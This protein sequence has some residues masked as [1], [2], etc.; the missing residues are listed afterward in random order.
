MIIKQQCISC[1]KQIE[2]ELS[3]KQYSQLKDWIK[4]GYKEYVQVAIPTLKPEYREL[5]ISG[6][7]SECFDN[8]FKCVNDN[9]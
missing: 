5:F 1:K 2:I 8:I 6:Y 9:E 7:C 4:S 3:E